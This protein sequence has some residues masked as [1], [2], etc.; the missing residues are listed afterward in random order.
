MGGIPPLET[1]GFRP[2]SKAKLMALGPHFGLG[3]S[4]DSSEQ[5]TLK[6]HS[7]IVG[8]V[9][10]QYEHWIEFKK[11]WNWEQMWLLVKYQSFLTPFCAGRSTS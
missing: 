11:L 5:D 9:A 4:H 10:R 3:Y 8:K 7:S 2:F 6:D 1:H